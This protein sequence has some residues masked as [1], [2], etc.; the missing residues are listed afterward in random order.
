MNKKLVVLV[1]CVAIAALLPMFFSKKNVD[2][3]LVTINKFTDHPA[4]NAASD[5]VED[6]LRARIPSIMIDVQD[7]QGNS[8]YAFQIAKHQASSGPDAMVGIATPS[9]QSILKARKDQEIIVSFAAV[10]DAKSANLVDSTNVVGVT[11]KP[12]VED[13]V[14]LTHKLFPKKKIIGTLFNPGEIN[15]INAVERLKNIAKELDMLVVEAPVNSTSNIKM[16]T[17]KL[18]NEVDIIYIPQDNMIV[19][20]FEAVANITNA[21]NVPVID[22][23]PIIS[24]DDTYLSKGVLIALGTNYYKSGQQLGNMIADQIESGSRRNNI[25]DA[26]GDELQINYELLEKFGIDKSEIERLVK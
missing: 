6:A 11:D 9:A 1:I 13:L 26:D 4:L 10:T 16:A 17:Q 14:R 19:S 5:G 25:R 18:V 3:K 8:A 24:N 2:S 12:P 20:S 7:A 21:H 22:N 15:S 23:I